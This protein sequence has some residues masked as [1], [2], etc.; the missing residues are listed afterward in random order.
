MSEASVRALLERAQ[1]DPGFRERLESASTRE[2][3][4]QVVRDAGFDVGPDDL[5]TLRSMAGIEISDSDLER[6]A[7]GMSTG[8]VITSAEAGGTAATA[9]LM[10]GT[11]A[12]AAALA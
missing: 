9:A 12:A 8:S 4:R 10:I 1:S 7:G 6:I 11:A 2:E 3:K 5:E